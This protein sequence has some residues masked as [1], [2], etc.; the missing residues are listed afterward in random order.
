LGLRQSTIV[1]GLCGPII[2]FRRFHQPV[3]GKA[4]WWSPEESKTMYFGKLC[5][6][7]LHTTLILDQKGKFEMWT[8]KSQK[9]VKRRVHSFYATTN[10]IVL[11]YQNDNKVQSRNTKDNSHLKTELLKAP[12]SSNI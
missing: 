12:W 10:T 1:D 3:S 11:E 9:L 6:N 4:P 5:G 7:R 2:P 8:T